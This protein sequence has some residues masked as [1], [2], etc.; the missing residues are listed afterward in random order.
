MEEFI[1]TNIKLRNISLSIVVLAILIL[2][3]WIIL[4]Y[5]LPQE[6]LIFLVYIGIGLFLAGLLFL[7]RIQFM[8][9]LQKKYRDNKNEEKKSS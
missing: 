1:R 8:L 6:N 7:T 2:V 9:W 3:L 4:Y 5:T